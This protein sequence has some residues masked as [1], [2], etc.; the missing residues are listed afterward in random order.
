MK[1]LF[2]LLLYFTVSLF[3]D[4]NLMN[5][6]NYLSSFTYEERKNM[7]I[8]SIELAVMLEDGEAQLIDIRFK[9]EYEAW[10]MPASINI[11]LNELPKRL[12]ELDKSKLIVTACPHKDRAIM[13]R[14]FLKLKG[15]NT[16]YLTDGL[17]G[18]A[19]YWRGDKAKDFI[20]E[21]RLM[22]TKK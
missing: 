9:E 7:K 14:T 12:E 15:Y 16:R 6:E 22:K 11:P 1:K 3:S 17:V 4:V 13:A 8:N 18:L 19:Q 10:N 2:A 21:Y 20:D 5:Y